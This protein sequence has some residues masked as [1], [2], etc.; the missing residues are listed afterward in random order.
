MDKT[1]ADKLKEMAEVLSNKAK[2]I[3]Q[4]TRRRDA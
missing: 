4:R 1:L 3:K 2:E